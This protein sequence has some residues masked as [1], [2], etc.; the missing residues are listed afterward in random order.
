MKNLILLALSIF[1]IQASA[2]ADCGKK[3]CSCA[4]SENK[5]HSCSEDNAKESDSK[6][7]L[8]ISESNNAENKSNSLGRHGK[9]KMTKDKTEMMLAK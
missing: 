6:A 8:R 7:Q 3:D 2:W 4:C 5:K 1:L 9:A